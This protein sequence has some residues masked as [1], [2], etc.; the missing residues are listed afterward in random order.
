LAIDAKK[1]DPPDVRRPVQSS[2]GEDRRNSERKPEEGKI[3]KQSQLP[4]KPKSCIRFEP[5]AEAAAVQQLAGVP[6]IA[7]VKQG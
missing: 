6:P 1:L 4:V 3:A 2:G 5:A 7:G